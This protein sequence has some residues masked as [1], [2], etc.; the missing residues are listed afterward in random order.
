MFRHAGRSAQP[1]RV[2]VFVATLTLAL[3]GS[4]P[5][6]AADFDKLDSAIK[7]IPA[8]ASFYYSLMRNREQVE[9][10]LSSK[11]WAKLMS[12]PALAH[13][14]QL[15]QDKANPVAGPLQ[16]FQEWAKDP[17]NR[18]LGELLL[19]MVSHEIFVYGGSNVTDV[20][21]TFGQVMSAAQMEGFRQ[22]MD[23]EF[24]GGKAK[25]VDDTKAARIIL[26]E[27]V[28]KPEALA[29]PEIIL[30][31]KVTKPEV[32]VAQL[33]RLEKVLPMV[34]EQ[35]PDLKDR[36]QWI[37]V[38]DNEF[39][40]LTI[41]SKIMK[42]D[43]Q[44]IRQYEEKPGEYDA[45][46]KRIQDLKITISLGVRGKHMLLAIAESTAAI[47][48]LGKGK[49]LIDTPELKP[50]AKYSDQRI[51]DIAYASK[52]FRSRTGTS[53]FFNFDWPKLSA[54]VLESKQFASQK[55]EAQERI[56]KDLTAFSKEMQAGEPKGGA[57]LAFTFLS[58]R[59][60]EG[61]AYDWSEHPGLDGA[62]PLSILDHVGGDPLIVAAGRSKY[63]SQAWP[64]LVRWAK[65][66]FGYFEEYGVPAM[67]PEEQKQYQDVMKG[68]L[69][70]LKRFDEIT[71]KMFLPSLA[72]GQSALVIDAKLASKQWHNKLPPSPTPIVV[73]EIALVIGVSDA[74]QLQKAMGE[75]RT[76]V[77][78][79]LALI[80]E[81]SPNDKIP[82]TEIPAP[83]NRKI[84]GGTIFFYPLPEPLGLD[85]QLLPNAGVNE[86]V[87]VL[88]LS[89]GHSERL[90]TATPLK[91]NGG[92]LAD[93]KRPLAGA[94]FVNY[95]G[96]VDLLAGWA[97][98]AAVF[99]P[100]QGDVKVADVLAQARI[101]FDVLKVFRSHSSATYFQE[102]ALVTHSEVVIADLK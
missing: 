98:A 6:R 78:E 31:F 71:G 96:L 90:L 49:R 45:V 48:K 16:Q 26:S 21:N 20:S 30:G 79:G 17:E 8:D 1:F 5:S 38:G 14:K 76:L 12:L 99:V 84:K 58:S 46:V 10:V 13:V 68:A 81:K 74:A 70:L 41:D 101:V 69:P 18:Q 23:E 53:V 4:P 15:A 92:P 51:T 25:P 87:A 3:V 44:M 97:E 28:K 65:V 73:P 94:V 24:T 91:A 77:N 72:D 52:A 93:L 2:F 57:S 54:V 67:K 75:Y 89:E 85:K 11:A 27:L 19:D 102:G 83:E 82:I 32:A 29:V 56:R 43:E 50:L 61:Y 7:D 95:A 59:G 80:R 64:G 66:G 42:F 35:F 34:A 60:K 63:D 22:A 39:L 88:T 47:A 9:A 62:K 40:S 55:P 100:D 33:K 36:L 37:K 86:K